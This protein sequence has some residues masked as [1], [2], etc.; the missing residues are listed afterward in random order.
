MNITERIACYLSLYSEPSNVR[1]LLN[2]AADEI[3]RL[4]E[5]MMTETRCP[6]CCG[7]LSYCGEQGMDGPAL[8]CLVC[9]QQAE[10]DR[11]RSLVAAQ[12]E[13]LVCYRLGRAPSGNVLDRI[14]KLKAGGS[15]V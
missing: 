2:D 8:D 14:G 3:E 12:D 1:D 4:R 6:V 13:L 15:D 5:A 11:L 9:R 7:E 10:I